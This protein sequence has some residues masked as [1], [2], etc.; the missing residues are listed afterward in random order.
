MPT[1]SR[2]VVLGAG[3]DG[4]KLTTILSNAFGDA[5]DIVLIDKSDS[6]VFGFSQP[7]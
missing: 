3:F 6:F 7:P 5:I 4:P 1:R 2:V